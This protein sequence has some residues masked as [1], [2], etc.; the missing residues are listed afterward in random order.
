MLRALLLLMTA[1]SS[2]ELADHHAI[3]DGIDIVYRVA[4]HG[5][6]ALV[7]PG[8]P[9]IEWRYA[10]MPELEHRLTL[11]YIEPIGTGASGR[12]ADPEGYTLHA[13]AQAIEAVRAAIGEDKIVVIGHSHGGKVAMQ[14]AAEHANHLRGLVLYSTSAVTDQE[15]SHDLDASIQSFAG[16]S[17]FAEAKAALQAEHPPADGN[18]CPQLS[19]IIG[20]YFADY[21]HRRDDIAP[22]LER[23]R[24]WHVGSAHDEPH[25]DMR[26]RLT[27]L[28][29]PTLVIT[30]R[31]DW[32]FPE[33]WARI[34][35]AA[36]KD[37][38]VV[39]LDASG[40]FAHLEQPVEFARAVGDFVDR[41][42]AI[43]RLTPPR[44]ADLRHR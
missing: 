27:N 8:G 33:K 30:G 41:V 38:T 18:S 43:H 42:S 22:I 7:H 37:A 12:L 9:G 16:T 13:Y 23:L 20:F 17:W 15:W 10:R 36:I 11:I 44:S 35:S 32:L 29:V 1:C 5:P 40:H 6:V 3:S 34:T 26:P 2:K 39:I 31:R 14:Y 28:R 24:C 19:S 25:D 21:E 4:G